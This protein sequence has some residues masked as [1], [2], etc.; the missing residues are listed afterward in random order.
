MTLDIAQWI[1]WS[2]TGLNI[3]L[4]ALNWRLTRLGRRLA[5]K[6]AQTYLELVQHIRWTME[7]LVS[8][9]PQIAEQLEVGL[10]ELEK[11]EASTRRVAEGRRP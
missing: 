7:D 4:T 9:D 1:V 6:E 3:I 5:R 2:A 8:R 11:L 10:L